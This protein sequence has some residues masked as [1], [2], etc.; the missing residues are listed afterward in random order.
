MATR[1]VGGSPEE[2]VEQTEVV[3]TSTGQRHSAQC[4]S[5]EALIHR[6]ILMPRYVYLPIRKRFA[7]GQR[8]YCS[9]DTFALLAKVPMKESSL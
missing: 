9:R 5:D 7:A 1:A 8:G 6:C 4:V 2:L 3:K